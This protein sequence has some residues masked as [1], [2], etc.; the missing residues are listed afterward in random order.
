[1]KPVTFKEVNTVFA[2]DQPQ[3]R[4]LPAYVHIAGMG[5]VVSCWRLTFW[6]RLKL[7]FT[8]RVWLSLAMFGKP[9]TPSLVSVD[10]C[11]MVFVAY[12]GLPP[13]EE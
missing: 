12:E 4:P 6:E 3:Y 5:E 9:L 10:R 1:M 8:G 2:K 11:D 13:S 7:L